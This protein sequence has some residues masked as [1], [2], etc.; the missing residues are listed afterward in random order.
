M[1]TKKS[2]NTKVIVDVLT[3]RTNCVKCKNYL[4]C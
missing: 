1:T 2:K 3:A 4:L